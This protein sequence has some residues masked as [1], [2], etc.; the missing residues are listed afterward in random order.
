MTCR[1]SS[2]TDLR[3]L[4]A[5]WTPKPFTEVQLRAMSHICH[6]RLRLLRIVIPAV[7]GILILA[8]VK[9]HKSLLKWRYDW[10]SSISV[11][12]PTF[13]HG[14]N[15]NHSFGMELPMSP[16]D[17]IAKAVQ[18]IEEHRGCGTYSTSWLCRTVGVAW[19]SSGKWEVQPNIL[20]LLRCALSWDKTILLM[21]AVTLLVG[22]AAS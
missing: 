16:G 5:S 20:F 21:G 3:T 9:Y 12:H 4:L 17:I 2:R 1:R 6:L 7:L 13:D 19:T 8:M 14:T 18:V 22:T 10:T 15:K 11:Y